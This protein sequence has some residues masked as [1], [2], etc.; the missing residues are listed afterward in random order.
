[1]KN[2]PK[3]DGAM[4]TLTITSPRDKIVQ[5]AIAVILEAIYEP[6]FKDTSYGFRPKRSTHD[7]LAKI[8][9]QG[10]GYS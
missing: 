4:R 10:A 2:I 3:E 7:A 6:I 9:L 5:K 1:L 8:K